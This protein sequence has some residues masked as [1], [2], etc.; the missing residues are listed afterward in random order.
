[1]DMGLGYI[2]IVKYKVLLLEAWENLFQGQKR[3][4]LACG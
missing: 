1:M 2:W 3:L 4:S